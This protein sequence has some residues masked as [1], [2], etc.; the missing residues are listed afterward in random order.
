MDMRLTRWINWIEIHVHL[1][2]NCIGRLKLNWGPSLK[3]NTSL[4][5]NTNVRPV[6]SLRMS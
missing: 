4:R 3:D 6:L 2:H 1:E 5:R